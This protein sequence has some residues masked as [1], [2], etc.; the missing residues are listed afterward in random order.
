[1]WGWREVDTCPKRDKAWVADQRWVVREKI[2]PAGLGRFH[3]PE[4]QEAAVQEAE[5]IS[6]R[7]RCPV[8]QDLSLPLYPSN[9]TT[10]S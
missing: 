6:A 5:A 7:K 8:I 10:I 1:M 9:P 3:V 2:H 4:G